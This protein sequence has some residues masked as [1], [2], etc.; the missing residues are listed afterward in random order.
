MDLRIASVIGGFP[1]LADALDRDSTVSRFRG[2]SFC[3]NQDLHDCVIY[4]HDSRKSRS[5]VLAWLTLRYVT[6][7]CRALRH[8]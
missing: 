7:L 8:V 1:L 2:L 3:C 4:D 5:V 6:Q